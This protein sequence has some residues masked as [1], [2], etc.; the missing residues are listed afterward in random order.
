MVNINIIY[1]NYVEIEIY[2]QDRREKDDVIGRQT[3]I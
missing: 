3:D 2:L 1:I